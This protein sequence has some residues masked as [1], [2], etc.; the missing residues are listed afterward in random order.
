MER[1]AGRLMSGHEGMAVASK[2]SSAV[3]AEWAGAR[4]AREASHGGRASGDEIK[5]PRSRWLK[6]CESSWGAGVKRAGRESISTRESAGTRGRSEKPGFAVVPRHR[7]RLSNDK[8][9]HNCRRWRAQIE[10]VGKIG[11]LARAAQGFMG[12]NQQRLQPLEA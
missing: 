3:A 7:P 5:G 11:H 6:C 1:R 12:S 10:K 8:A 9:D 2:G 4:P